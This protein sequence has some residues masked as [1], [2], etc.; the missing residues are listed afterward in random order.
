MSITFNFL[1][2]NSGDAILVSADHKNILIDGGHSRTYY[3]VIK[4]QL[5]KIKEEKQ[6]LD[7]VV[8]THLDNDHINGLLKLLEDKQ[9]I[10]LVK[11]LWFNAFN[12][13]TVVPTKSSYKTSIKQGITFDEF[14]EKIKT[15]NYSLNFEKYI[16]IEKFDSPIKLFSHLQLTLLSPN[17]NK[18]QRLYQDYEKY[19]QEQDRKKNLTSSKIGDYHDD[20][21][22]LAKKK[23]E[24]DNSPTNGSSIAFILKY[25]KSSQFLL[26]ADAHIDLIVHSLKER[27]YSKQ[28][29][30]KID[31]V[32][33]SHHGSKHNLNQDLL[34]II[35]T[36]MFIISTNGT[37]KHPDKETLCKIIMNP[38]RD[39][40]KKIN[41]IF[42]YK[43]VCDRF[44]Q[45]FTQDFTEDERSRYNFNLEDIEEKELVFGE[46]NGFKMR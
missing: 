22:K 41:L 33:L 42:N 43:T 26:L 8:L 3:R 20:V 17:E 2:A 21:E 45:I 39:K 12:Q 40:T 23:F 38:E 29:P 30:L 35:D 5:K 11:E 6:Y 13:F 24:K 16:S 9:M 18:L 28:K 10:L 37:H 34:D 27:G 31:F 36:D 7:L 19:K 46:S 15:E 32:K 4:Q 44:K 14:V 1:P 25:K